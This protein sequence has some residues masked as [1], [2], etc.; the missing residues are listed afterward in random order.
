MTVQ[1][2][3]KSQ[4]SSLSSPGPEETNG[5]H[6][7]APKSPKRKSPTSRGSENLSV[8]PNNPRPVTPDVM[9]WNTQARIA[10]RAY[11]MYE[12]RMHLGASLQDWVR[13]E[14]EI[15]GIMHKEG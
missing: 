9:D 1:K 10:A 7:S 13:A 4:H 12:E 15:L 5:T 8:S 11:E 2:K 3:P 14:Q 6:S